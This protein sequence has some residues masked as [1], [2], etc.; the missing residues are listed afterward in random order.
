[1]KIKNNSTKIEQVSKLL[2]VKLD[3]F[4]ANFIDIETHEFCLYIEDNEKTV[5]GGI[6]GEKYGKVLYIHLLWI[7]ETLRGLGKGSELLID[8]E[9]WAISKNCTSIFLDT[10]SFQAPG[11]YI[12][13]GYTPFGCTKIDDNNHSRIYFQKIIT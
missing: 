11:F 2:S 1:M 4:N 12:S 9:K 7:D 13:M 10:F 3:E 5:K 6:V 8:A